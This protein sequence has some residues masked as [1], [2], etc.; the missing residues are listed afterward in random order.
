[1][2]SAYFK[3]DGAFPRLPATKLAYLDGDYVYADYAK[4]A[5][6]HC[7]LI[8]PHMY[9]PPE[10]CY[11]VETT[12]LPGFVVNPYGKGKGIYIPWSPGALFH[13]QGHT[14]T[15]CLIAD[16]LEGWAGL[17]PLG[18]NLSP[19]V[20]ATLF[21]RRGG[22]CQLLH[23]VN[24]SGHFGTTFY[25]PVTMRDLKVVIPSSSKPSSTVS[26]VTGQEYPFAH[27]DGALTI[28]IPELHLFEAVKIR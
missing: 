28:Q 25:E 14:N 17:Q 3:L 1:M 13:R 7:R 11:Y 26:L 6:K 5:G 19:M 12:D 24:G 10:R 15:I 22:D 16:V 4:E 27:A 2:R 21:E 9:G 20:E 8:P 18:G 23:L